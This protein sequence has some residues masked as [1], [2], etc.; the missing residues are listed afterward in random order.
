M[1]FKCEITRKR[2]RKGKPYPSVG[3]GSPEE[4]CPIILKVAWS[5]ILWFLSYMLRG[6]IKG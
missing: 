2:L 5:I 3:M 4:S 6:V 1:Y